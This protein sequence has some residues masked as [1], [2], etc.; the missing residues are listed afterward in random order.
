MHPTQHAYASPHRRHRLLR[1]LILTAAFLCAVPAQ[2][3]TTSEGARPAP[4]EL[5]DDLVAA[6][7]I[8]ATEGVVDGYGHV[9]MRHPFNPQHF[10]IAR[11]MAPELVGLKDI[12]ELDMDGRHV[13]ADDRK[14]YLERFIHAEIYKARSD[15]MAIVHHHSPAV[16]PFS[17]TG[18]P[19]RPVYHM[20]AFIG[21]GVPVFEIREAGGVT[22]MLVSNPGLGKAL[23]QTLAG[24]PASLMRGH[25]AVVVGGSLM[26]AV[27]RSVYMQMNARLQAQAMA[28]GGEVTYLSDGEVARLAGPAW[29]DRAWEMWKWR[30]AHR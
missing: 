5:L 1:S 21:L 13:Q 30:D 27:A 19:L 11:S 9:S 6:N 26:E 10:L 2:S 7:H 15:V 22:D 23:A 25:G 20:A 28:L 4:P 24:K 16:L 17:V 18:V 29:Y 3:D 14:L 12:V 8:L